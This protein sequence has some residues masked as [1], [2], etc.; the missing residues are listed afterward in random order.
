M[1]YSIPPFPDGETEAHEV[2]DCPVGSYSRAGAEPLV[3]AGPSLASP[4][5]VFPGFPGILCYRRGRVV[6]FRFLGHFICSLEVIGSS[7]ENIGQIVTGF[8]HG[9]EFVALSLQNSDK[10]VN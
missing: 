9:G 1:D 3:E 4:T 7:L 5:T 6:A 10:I 8:N 2:L